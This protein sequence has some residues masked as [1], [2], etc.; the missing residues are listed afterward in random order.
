M[1]GCVHQ[2]FES[3]A[4]RTPEA[5]A[6]VFEDIRLTYRQLN[7]RAN[8]L[9][10]HL[11][12][13]GVRAEMPVCLH[14]ERSVELIVGILAVL[15][16]GGA[17][18][19]LDP[20]Y[21]TQRLA[22]IVDDVDTPVLVTQSVPE[23]E[24][25][26]RA[27][28]VVCLDRDAPEIAGH[29]TSNPNISV[30]P[31]NLLYIIYTS[32]STGR[33]KG[34][35]VEHR[36]V[37][38]LFQAAGLHVRTDGSDTWTLFHSCSFGFS[39][40]EIWG[41]LLQGGRLVVVSRSISLSPIA[42]FELVCREQVTVLSLTPSAFR[43]FLEAEATSRLATQ[44]LKLIVFSGEP[45]EPSLL[46]PW[47]TSHG[48]ELP[49]LI[50]MYALTE[51]SGEVAYRRLTSEDL[52]LDT[53]SVIGFPLSNAEIYILDEDRQPVSTGTVGELYIGGDA[54]ARGYLGLPEAAAERF[55]TDPI[56]PGHGGKCYRTGD[57]GRILPNGEIELL[58]RT[59]HQ[60]KI[61]G[62]RIEPGE[63]ES[64]LR[65]H[66]DIS[67]AVVLARDDTA[68]DIL[69]LEHGSSVKRLV[70]YVVPSENGTSAHGRSAAHSPT[71]LRE[72]VRARLPDYMVPNLFV[73][74][75]ELPMM[76]N[77]KLDR[78]AL[79]APDRQRPALRVD[80]SPPCGPAEEQLVAIWC[81]VFGLDQ[82]GVHDNFF[83]LGGNSLMAV[84]LTT[85]VFHDFG[86]DVALREVFE[87]PTVA[88]M[89]ELVETTRWVAARPGLAVAGAVAPLEDGEL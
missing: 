32:G 48:D 31:D 17:Y 86:V 82:V 38:R 10:R 51:T 75:D 64:V 87:T 1:D 61:L 60:I 9:A 81:E 33:P 68:P 23:P 46:R 89:A 71:V 27:T 21:P 12:L 41:A 35:L 80:Y 76:P 26:S 57:R 30:T 62:F 54:V 22:F 24:F 63:I 8:Q 6:L 55:V 49:Q 3:Q 77:G 7:E 43:L 20:G 47:I 29:A 18:V 70:A 74:L 5:V 56:A 28:T 67:E 13:Q 40:W 44:H 4:Q 14:L 34:V 84:N 53:R 88:E 69:G 52:T 78:R 25:A 15:K 39:Q 50:N 66:Q 42:F 65:E 59:D 83:E 37:V 45:L 58:G 85:R 73:V 2:V 72:Y 19:P 79:P 11:V 36:G 16:A